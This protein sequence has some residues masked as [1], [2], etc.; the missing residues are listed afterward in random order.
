MASQIAK[1]MGPTCGPPGSCRPQ[2]GPMLSPWALLSGILRLI[3]QYNVMVIY[4]HIQNVIGIAFYETS[5]KCKANH[6]IRISKTK[7]S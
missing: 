4:G 2:M 7:R 6:V 1:F 3:D 5:G